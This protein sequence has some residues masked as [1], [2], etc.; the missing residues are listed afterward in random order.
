MKRKNKPTKRAKRGQKD[1]TADPY[2][3][4]EDDK[5]S[6]LLTFSSDMDQQE[7]L[8]RLKSEVAALRKEIKGIKSRL[9][10][11]ERK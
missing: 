3:V 1:L 5:H 4:P 7:S 8:F 10:K 9:K 2:H 6:R 11:L